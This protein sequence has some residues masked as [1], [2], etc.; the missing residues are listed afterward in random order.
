MGDRCTGHCCRA[1]TLPGSP[2]ELVRMLWAW[3]LSWG[4]E[5]SGYDEHYQSALVVYS[6]DGE[7]HRYQWPQDIE[8]IATMAIHLGAFRAN[9]VSPMD[10]EGAEGDGGEP[11][12]FYTCRHFDP[13]TSNC[14]IYASRPRMC[15]EY[16]YGRRCHYVDCAW[17][18]ARREPEL[19]PVAVV[20]KAEAAA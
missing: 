15:I 6:D 3:L 13:A 7:R 1:F 10:G 4:D 18:A 11:M 20:S 17:A 12:H 8:V 2:A 19:E 9:P 16:P 14:T 5:P